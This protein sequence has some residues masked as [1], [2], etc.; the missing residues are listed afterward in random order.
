MYW[1]RRIPA[2]TRIVVLVV[3]LAFFQAILL[4]V[5]GLG[6]IWTERRQAAQQLSDSAEY[7]LQQYVADRCQTVLRERA[8]QA[9]RAAFDLR[10][11]GWRHD[12]SASGAGLFTDAFL[13]RP[14]GRIVTPDDQPLWWPPESVDLTQEVARRRSDE[15]KDA[16][17]SHAFDA[18]DKTEQRL[19][20]ARDYPFARDELGRSL[21]L[22]HGATP[23][24]VDPRPP[25][26]R[27][28]LLRMRWIGVLNRVAGY[29]DAG[30][31]QRFLDRIDAA[32]GDDASY[33]AGATEQDQ[34]ARVL[35]ELRRERISML[36]GGPPELHRNVRAAPGV[37]F[38]VRSVGRAG[39]LQVLAVNL[40]RLRSVTA[41]VVELS[42]ARAPAGVFPRVV[43]AEEKS[44]DVSVPINSL[45][46][47][48]ATAEIT[49]D[50]VLER[51]S[52]G[53]TFYKFIIGF[54]VAG[55]LAGGVLTARAV[56]REMKL[57]KLKSGFVSNVSHAL[58]TPLT[59]IRMFAEM[60]RSG[61]VKDE[62]ERDECL[63]V[64]A[65]ETQRLG[66]L[67]QQVLDFGRLEARRRPF[68]WKVGSLEPILKGEAE[69]FRR[70]TGL[71][72]DR[73]QVRIAVNLPPV[74]HDP[75]AFGEVIANLLSNAFKYTV[76]EKRRI[77]LTAGPQRGR[78]V[79]SVEDNGPGIPLRERKKIFEQFYRVHD[80]LTREVEGTGLGLSIARNIV[81]AHGG[82]IL[83]E[84]GSRG[85]SRFVVVL[86]AAPRRAAAPAAAEASR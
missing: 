38:Y 28:T 50:A 69:R 4:S 17:R 2:E 65:K 10:A 67:I 40:E 1:L 73:F 62:A 29:V 7:F 49:E 64:I 48:L 58:K 15:L 83:V 77:E 37:R 26:P 76:P 33:H 5:F 9:F 21:A 70:A 59:S 30:E 18:K 3:F 75:E 19:V 22:L 78:V 34:R 81:R 41:D 12:A 68:R 31:V 47:F 66:H 55:I 84:D 80:L 42:K 53:E 35:E 61:K 25:P 13:V 82:R 57:A 79:V 32:A 23:L 74:N 86:P 72:D 44:D 39:D 60:L 56:M 52:E 20:F 46:G 36:P 71:T 51:A 11:T 45:P 24:F 63:A 54:S 27:E 8:Q 85:G 6:A 16:Y 14:D 43:E